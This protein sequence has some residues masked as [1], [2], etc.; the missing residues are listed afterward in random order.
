[1]SNLYLY[2]FMK[3]FPL[4]SCFVIPLLLFISLDSNAQTIN[5]EWATQINQTF[6]GLDKDKIPHSLV[7]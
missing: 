5:T 1:M 6:S 3:F 2:K 4:K 7:H